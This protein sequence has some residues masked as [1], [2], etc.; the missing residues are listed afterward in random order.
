VLHVDELVVAGNSPPA[1]VADQLDLSLAE[2]YPA[3]AYYHEHPDEM[4]WVRRAEERS[5]GSL[6]ERSLS[7]PEPAE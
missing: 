5:E 7:P 1:D 4:R 2:V 3:L 6:A